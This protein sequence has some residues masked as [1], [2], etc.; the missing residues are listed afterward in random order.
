MAMV[1]EVM[2]ILGLELLLA[3]LLDE[4]SPNAAL[5][6]LLVEVFTSWTK[7]GLSVSRFFS[8]KPQK[9]GQTR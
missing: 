6:S 7:S 3:G 8:R 5:R 9:E 1:A 2:T 4:T